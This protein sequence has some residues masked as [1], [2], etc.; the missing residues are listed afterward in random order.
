MKKNDVQPT[1]T[2]NE[3]IVITSRELLDHWQAHRRVTRR[4]I[5]AFPED[6]LFTH[7][8]GGMRPFAELVREMIAM[9]VPGMKGVVTGQWEHYKEA[10]IPSTKKELLQVWDQV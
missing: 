10:E 8:V 6:K 5:E 4:V 1:E 3:P 9:A 7:S 2:K